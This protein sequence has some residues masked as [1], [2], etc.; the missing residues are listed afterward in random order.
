[1]N[2]SGCNIVITGTSCF[3]GMASSTRVRNLFEPLVKKK[4]ITLGNLIFESDNREPIGREGVKDEITFRIIGFRLSNPFSIF[5]FWYRGFSFLKKNRKKGCKNVLYNYNYPDLKNIFFLLYAKMLGYRIIVDIVEDNRFEPHLGILNK[6]R[7]K[8]SV[9]LFSI[10]RH[11]VNGYVAISE[12][13]RQRCQEVSKGKKP[14]EL[15]PVTV[16]LKYFP[17][18]NSYQPDRNDLKM[19]YGG[20]FGEKD[21]LGYLVDAFGEICQRHDKLKLILTGAGNSRDVEKIRSRIENSPA[22]NNIIFKG[23]LSTPDYYATLNSCDIFCMTRVNSKF[24]NAGFPFKLGEF[25]A[26]GKAVIATRV[27]DV[28]NYLVND[29]NSVLIE[30]NSTEG[31]VVAIETIIQHP[32]KINR[33]GIEARKTAEN[34]FDSEKAGIRLLALFDSV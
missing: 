9:F 14:I 11:F 10:S 34:N 31:L 29:V 23:F 24:A 30:P 8:T 25:M 13:L 33:L 21:G 1:M 2:Y 17:K 12:H 28:S 27:G 7:L 16:N 4:L 32:D 19:F 5:S 6:I 26:S 18:A 3:D 22:K 15:I 20:S